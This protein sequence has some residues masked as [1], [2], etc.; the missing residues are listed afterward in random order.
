MRVVAA[1]VDPLTLYG[2]ATEMAAGRPTHQPCL[3]VV[4]SELRAVQREGIDRCRYNTH[5]N[6]SDQHHA[7]QLPGAIAPKEPPN[8]T[9]WHAQHPPKEATRKSSL[10]GEN[11]SHRCDLL[12]S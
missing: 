11:G 7:Q 5:R 12:T 6:S 10:H 2:T 3:N 9:Q 1:A 8:G 4:S